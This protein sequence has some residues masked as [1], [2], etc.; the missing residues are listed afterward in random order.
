[1][2]VGRRQVGGA[3]APLIDPA[4]CWPALWAQTCSH[5]GVLRNKSHTCERARSAQGGTPSR[6]GASIAQLGGQKRASRFRAASPQGFMN[7][8]T[9]FQSTPGK[10]TSTLRS[11]M[12][13][14]NFSVPIVIHTARIDDPSFQISHFTPNS[15][16]Q[17]GEAASMMLV[18]FTSNGTHA[19]YTK[20]EID[21]H[22]R[23]SRK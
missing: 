21:A 13:S 5:S 10:V 3:P 23:S 18:E 8:K 12:I 2:A 6:D 11:I 9:K 7:D 22:L 20:D 4:T 15:L 16:L 1:M 17:P 14:N 19:L